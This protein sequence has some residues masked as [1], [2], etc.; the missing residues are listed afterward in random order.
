MKRHGWSVLITPEC[1]VM[2]TFVVGE[3][4][5]TVKLTFTP[6]YPGTPVAIVLTEPFAYVFPS[7]HVDEQLGDWLMDDILVL[8]TDL[9]DRR[10]EMAG[11]LPSITGVAYLVLGANP[12]EARRGRFFSLT[13]KRFHHIRG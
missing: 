6:D 4:T 10:A 11:R 7:V 8:T 5:C 3:E 13:I 9:L 12:Y 1:G 2:A